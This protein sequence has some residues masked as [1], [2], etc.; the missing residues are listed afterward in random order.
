MMSMGTNPSF[1]PRPGWC[2][3]LGLLHWGF[4]VAICGGF[5]GRERTGVSPSP[6]GTY[7]IFSLGYNQGIFSLCI[8]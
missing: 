8:L 7:R 1:A 2:R 6:G 3:V 4:S 5:G